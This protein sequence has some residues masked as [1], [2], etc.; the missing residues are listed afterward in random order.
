MANRPNLFGTSST[1]RL[2]SITNNSAN[3]IDLREQFDDLIFG[4]NTRVG[5]GHLLV[6]RHMRREADGK[7]TAC[8]C[9]DP[10]SFQCDPDCPYCLGEGYLWDETWYMGRSQFLGS[11]GGL[12]NRYRFLPPGE[13]RADTKV[14]FFRYD[15]PI[16]YGDK[17]V[18]MKLDSEGAPVVPYVRQAIYKPQAINALRG[19]NGR[20]EFHTIYCLEKDA[21]R[22]DN[23]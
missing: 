22:S 21:I 17:I 10:M 16:Q 5:K 19:D 18:E 7:A 11:D 1:N 23:L 8:T 14:F 3:E 6:I 20:V 2:F 13:V 9:L 15:V 4:S 12:G